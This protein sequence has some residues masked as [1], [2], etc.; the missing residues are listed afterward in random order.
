MIKN[1][2]IRFNELTSKTETADRYGAG[3]GEGRRIEKKKWKEKELS[4][5]MSTLLVNKCT[6][7]ALKR[8]NW[9]CV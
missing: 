4:D 3:C 2:T 5:E 9:N 8:L 1:Q 6:V 7:L